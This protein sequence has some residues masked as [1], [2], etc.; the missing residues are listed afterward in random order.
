MTFEL[1]IYT[2]IGS[3]TLGLIAER[4]WEKRVRRIESELRAELRRAREI[5][6]HNQNR[7]DNRSA[8]WFG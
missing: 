2:I 6:T 1:W 3:I 7:L 8:N 4:L 5:E